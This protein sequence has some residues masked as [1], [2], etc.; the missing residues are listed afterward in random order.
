MII[1]ETASVNHDM[2]VVWA[3]TYI[4]LEF[5]I[6][7]NTFSRIA[8]YDTLFIF[9]NPLAKIYKNLLLDRNAI[10]I[11]NGLNK[12]KNRPVNNSNPNSVLQLL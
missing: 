11:K 9:Q 6:F 1:Y 5:I 12:S 8:H 10:N 4:S 7:K 2:S 3:N